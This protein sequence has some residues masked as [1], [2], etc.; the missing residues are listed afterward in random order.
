MGAEQV[1]FSVGGEAA[2]RLFVIS[3]D[4]NNQQYDVT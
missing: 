1:S 4:W 3:A 2:A